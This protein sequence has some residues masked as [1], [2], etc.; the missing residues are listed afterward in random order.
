MK[1]MWIPTLA[2]LAAV[3]HA[4]NPFPPESSCVL[5]GTLEARTFTIASRGATIDLSPSRVGALLGGV[6]SGLGMP[7]PEIEDPPSV[8]GVSSPPSTTDICVV[9]GAMLK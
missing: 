6:L 1:S 9:L 5:G 8:P 2:A 3:T 7:P 4:G